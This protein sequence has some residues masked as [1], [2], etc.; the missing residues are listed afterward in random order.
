M[1][2]LTNDYL[3][4]NSIWNHKKLRLSYNL[5]VMRLIEDGCRMSKDLITRTKKIKSL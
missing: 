5:E 1:Q 4:L 2:S 3:E